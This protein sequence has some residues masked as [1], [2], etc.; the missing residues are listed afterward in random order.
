M[1]HPSEIEIWSAKARQQG[2]R[3]LLIVRDR[4]LDYRYPLYARTA[5]HVHEAI[6]GRGEMEEVEQVMDLAPEV[7]A[8]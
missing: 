2:I 3:F 8:K 7:E 5:Q 6:L 4:A 1:K